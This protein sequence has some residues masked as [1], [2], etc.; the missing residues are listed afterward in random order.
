MKNRRAK[1][2]QRQVAWRWRGQSLSALCVSVFPSP[3][4]TPLP[5][6]LPLSLKLGG[7]SVEQLGQ[8]QEV[9]VLVAWL[10]WLWTVTGKGVQ[11]PLLIG[12]FGAW[13]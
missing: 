4:Q 11:A 5:R 3:A 12:G 7:V 2:E 9:G 10:G 8:W 1:G 6:S 13:K